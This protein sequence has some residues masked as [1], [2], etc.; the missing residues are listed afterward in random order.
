[1]KLE[2]L[3]QYELVLRERLEDIRTDG[4]LLRHKKS[5][6][7][8]LVLEN[9]D[10]NKV[11]NI[12]FRTPPEN[13]KGV[14]H[15]LEHSVLCGSR[16]FP[17]KDPFVELVKG[18]LNTF[19]NAMTYPDKT[20]YPVASC[21]D[22]DFR[23]LM[24]VYLDAVFYPNIYHKK[25]IFLQ[26]GWSY[27]LESPG[28]ELIYNGVVYNEMKGV[29]SSPES[30][31]DY[32][33]MKSLFPD[34]TYG[35]ESGGAPEWIPQLSYEEFL[36]FHR[37]YYHPSNSYIY[38]YGNMDA[39]E[40][41]NW[42]DREYLSCF[43]KKQVDSAIRLQEPFDR[44]VEKSLPYSV[45]ENEGTEEKDYLSYNAA[46]GTSLDVL[47]SNAFAVLE[48]ALLSS[49]GAVLKQALLDAGIGKDIL[50]SYDSGIYQPVFSIIAKNT[51]KDK[52]EEFLRIIREELE[53]AASQG[54][55]RDAL[56]AGINIMEFKAREADYGSYPKGL[57]YG[58]NV[59]DTWLYD[60]NRPF[61][62][63]KLDVYGKLR[64]K[65]EEGYFEEI[66]RRYLLENT[67]ASVVILQPEPGLTEQKDRAVREKLKAY[68]ESLTKEELEAL[69]R[70]TEN[71]R[72]FQETPSTQ[73]EL[74]KIPMLA[75]EDIGKEARKFSNTS[76]AWEGIPVLHHDL[77]T[78]GIAYLDFLFEIKRISREE[79]PYLGI[80]KAVL[81]M[82][83]TENYSYGTLNYEINKN[84]G[85]I[86]AGISVFPVL[87][88]ENRC[89]VFLGIKA[90]ALYDQLP[91]V[92][93]MTE[94]ILC[95][96]KLENDRRLYEILAM[97]KS[98]MSMY[99]SSSGH[100]TAAVRAMSYFSETGAYNDS[101]SGIRY[102]RLLEELEGNF[103]EKKEELK[104]VLKGML[105]KLVCRDGFLLSVTCDE[106]GLQA[107]REAGDEF[108]CRL[109]EGKGEILNSHP[110]LAVGNEGF[111]TPGQ[112][113]YVARAGNFRKG[114]FDYKGTLQLLKVL[115]S[116]DYLWNHIRVK[117]G[118]YGCMS[119]F[120][121]SGD[122]YFVS[123][124]DPN[125]EKT[126]QVYEGIPEYLE[127]F[128][129][130]ERDMTKYIIGT[131][132]DLDMPLTP[133]TA[134]SRSLHAYISGITDEEV[135]RERN[136]ILEAE[137][138]DVRG[139]APLVREILRQDHLCV[140]GNETK[141]KE[142][143]GLF[144]RLEPL[145]D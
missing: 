39:E 4:Y 56:Y 96:T 62:Y 2:N 55:D 40:R 51:S 140:I 67:H 115:M 58:I 23:N 13:S 137:P 7:R 110:T 132:S 141:L 82:V 124:R 72:K 21:N 8:I 44:P 20:M 30:V 122:A 84:T 31:L 105:D 27:Q 34:T 111:T 69:I 80:L 54:V 133:S 50:G 143:E 6:A 138:E 37:K 83:D 93:R 63:L 68:K 129:A 12:A 87:K 10:E 86:S 18:S 108:P 85:G 127:N 49:P 75:R 139:L 46:A 16:L 107:V 97:Q 59:F 88:E 24:H 57:I 128:T 131:I 130:T 145:A 38:L 113:Q 116:Y 144:G 35:V 43:D 123:Y 136:E 77:F 120:G 142:A 106:E 15:I 60:E 32:E 109:P 95:R 112:V 121:K 33:I 65:V 74:E 90:R 29:Y 119:S 117:G 100:G 5:G 70:Q 26:E 102:Y 104:A 66:I 64:Q 89:R 22:K 76:L 1:M 98:R 9:E 42:M 94:E 125:L 47:L 135:Q 25:E 41:L 11:F 126:N 103:Q 92:F 101:V 78:N 81:G 45:A 48:Y 134:G 28:E 53:K 61:D 17:A 114:G 91:F 36:D 79:I 118:A 52:K 14:A 71:L 19:L 99:L 3:P 73:E